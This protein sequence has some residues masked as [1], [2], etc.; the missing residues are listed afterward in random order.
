MLLGVL[1]P[2]LMNMAA[3][4]CCGVRVPIWCSMLD[5]ESYQGCEPLG[6]NILRTTCKV[7]T[8][9]CQT[10]VCLLY[11]RIHM[12]LP[13]EILLYGDFHVLLIGHGHLS[14]DN[15]YN[16]LDKTAYS[17]FSTKTY[18]VGTQKNRLSE[19]V[20][21]SNQNKC[22]NWWIRQYLQFDAQDKFIWTY[23]QMLIAQLYEPLVEKKRT[24]SLSFKGCV[25]LQ[26]GIDVSF[27]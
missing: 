20:L 21:L 23:A 24:G 5:Y 22:L 18:V 7:P 27:A 15:S 6:F 1:L 12:W 10:V 26:K 2:P 16:P 8:K 14:K 11:S 17:Y 19:T 4:R 3:L 13:W 25:R 9:E